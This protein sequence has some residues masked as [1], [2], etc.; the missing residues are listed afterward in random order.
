MWDF[1]YV[2]P[3][4]L[5]LCDAVMSI[6]IKVSQVNVSNFLLNLY[7]EDLMQLWR[8]KRVHPGISKVHLIKCPVSV[9]TLRH[10]RD[11]PVQNLHNM[12]GWWVHQ[13][14]SLCVRLNAVVILHGETFLL[15]LLELNQQFRFYKLKVNA[16]W[17]CHFIHLVCNGWCLTQRN[18]HHPSK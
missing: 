18:L 11:Q 16:L 9:Y 6:R 13:C 1:H 10:T 3:T 8:Q 5:Q 2:Q 7:H 15:R 17:Y 4:N 14:F 12:T